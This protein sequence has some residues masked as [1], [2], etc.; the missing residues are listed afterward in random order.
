MINWEIVAKE[1]LERLEESEEVS[2]CI[3]GSWFWTNSG[4]MVGGKEGGMTPPTWEE[5]NL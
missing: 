2:L 1:C 3:N 5:D 4:S